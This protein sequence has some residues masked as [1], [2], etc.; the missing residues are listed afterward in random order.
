MVGVQIQG[1]GAGFVPKTLDVEVVDEVMQVTSQE[2]VEMAR[3]LALEEGLLCGISSGT[4]VVAAIRWAALP[5]QISAGWS[6][7]SPVL[8][9][10]I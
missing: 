5:Q 8:P 9:A 6:G 4:A 3:R 7:A 2:S 10:R 1:I